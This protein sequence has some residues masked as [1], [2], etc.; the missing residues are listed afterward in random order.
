MTLEQLKGELVEYEIASSFVLT[1][2]PF[3][4][5]WIARYF[6]RKVERKLRRVARNREYVR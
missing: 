4:H 2:I 5:D 1:L 3:G 6:I